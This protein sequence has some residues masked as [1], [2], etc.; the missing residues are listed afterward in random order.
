LA[1]MSNPIVWN[2]DP[3]LVHLGPLAVRYYGICFG[4]ALATGFA[5]W[6]KRVRRLGESGA[7][8]EEF[9]YFGVPAVIIGGRLGYCFFYAPRFYVENPLRIVAIWQGGIASHGVAAGLAVTLWL[10]SRRH[11]VTWTRLSDYFAPAVALAVGWI[12]VGNFFNSEVIGRPASVPWAV[13]FARHDLVPR[14]P[15]QLYDMLIGPVTYLVLLAVERRNIRPI[16]SGLIAGTFLTVFFGLRIFV[17]QYKDFYI[18][19]LREMPPFRNIEQWLG[20]PIHTGQWLSILP[21]LAGIYLIARAMRSGA[22][23]SE[24]G[25]VAA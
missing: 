4:L 8:A 1:G 16:G 11:H 12:R 6:F 24:D 23:L 18:E 2:V 7:F 3:V 14:H 20:F 5:I 25:S 9:L 10:F 19:Q 15:A 13:V 22:L 21:V 17:E